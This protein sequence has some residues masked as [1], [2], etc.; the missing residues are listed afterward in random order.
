MAQNKINYFDVQPRSYENMESGQSDSVRGLH[1]AS[2]SVSE[3]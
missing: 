1:Q 3:Q 2:L